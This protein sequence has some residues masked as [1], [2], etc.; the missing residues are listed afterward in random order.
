MKTRLFHAVILLCCSVFFCCASGPAARNKLDKN[1]SAA[2]AALNEMSGGVSSPAADVSPASKP[3]IKKGKNGKPNWIN[4]S[5]SAYRK[6]FYLSA[7][8]YGK[9]PM[10]AEQ[11]ALGNLIAVFG[12]TVQSSVQAVE[13][14]KRDVESGAITISNSVS[15]E[16]AVKSSS[17]MDA[18][19]GAEI[20]DRWDDGK[21]FYA[22]A[23][24]DKAKCR[25]IYSD[26]FNANTKLI[27]TVL[28]S[29]QNKTS[30]ETVAR[31]YYASKLDA[32]NAVFKTILTV[33]GANGFNTET[34]GGGYKF[35]AWETAQNIPINIVVS[36]DNTGKIKSAFIAALAKEGFKTGDS[37]ARYTLRVKFSL[38]TVDLQNINKWARYAIDAQLTDNNSGLVLQTFTENGRE[39][40]INQ[41]EA[42][43]RAVLGAAEK[44]KDEYPAS[45]EDYFSGL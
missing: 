11:N 38:E 4:N 30:I 1:R 10:Q 28:G 25:Q 36:G 6:E 43:N 41:T 45:L 26:L 34:T 14:Y 27:K 21:T 8:G 9:N 7:V 5:G 35:A 24:M 19:F 39:G 18:L 12:Q 31:Y 33:L 32:V 15:A 37:S 16:Q 22:V 40:H 29:S 13:T 3:E 23:V 44:I 2:A 17:T 42:N 20:G